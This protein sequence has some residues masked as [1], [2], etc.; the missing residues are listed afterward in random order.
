M[1]S[2]SFLIFFV[3]RKTLPFNVIDVSQNGVN[4]KHYSRTKTEYYRERRRG[5]YKNQQ[6]QKE[7]NMSCV[8]FSQAAHVE[9]K[10]EAEE[11]DQREESN[12]KSEK[13]KHT[14]TERFFNVYKFDFGTQ[15]DSK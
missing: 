10:A 5:N 2:Q 6:Q 14:I 7:N 15:K 11:E 4:V 12:A 1:I 8:L 13:K 9:A 3:R